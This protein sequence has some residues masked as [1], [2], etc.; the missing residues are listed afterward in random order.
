MH[1]SQG[2]SVLSKVKDCSLDDLHNPDDFVLWRVCL[3]QVGAQ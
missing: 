1:C 2:L 3:I